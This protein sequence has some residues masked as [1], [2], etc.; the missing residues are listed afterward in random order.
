MKLTIE[1]LSSEDLDAFV[2]WQ[3]RTRSED[4]PL[5]DHVT[6]PLLLPAL[7]ALDRATVKDPEDR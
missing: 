1:F 5:A 6:G 3:S 2:A 7:L 4:T